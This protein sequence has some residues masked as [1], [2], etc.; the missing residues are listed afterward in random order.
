MKIATMRLFR[1]TITFALLLVVSLSTA[2][3]GHEADSR[4]RFRQI[5]SRSGIADNNIRNLQML[6]NGVMVLYT[7]TML[8]IYD[9]ISRSDLAFNSTFIPYK[10]YSTNVELVVTHDD[11][12]VILNGDR[13][14]YFDTRRLQ[15]EYHNDELF[16]TPLSSIC[17]IVMDGNNNYLIYTKDARLHSY[18]PSTATLTPIST[19][20]ALTGDIRMVRRGESIYILTRGGALFQYDTSLSTFTRATTSLIDSDT[21]DTSRFSL[22]VGSS[23]D[24]FA[25]YD[26]YLLRINA[27]T[28]ASTTLSHIPERVENIYTCIGIDSNERLWIG[29][30]KG[31]LSIIDLNTGTATTP[32]IEVMGNDQLSSKLEISNLYIDPKGG[33]WVATESEGVLY[34]HKD[35]FCLTTINDRI[36]NENIKCMTTTKQGDILLGTSHGLYAYNPARDEVSLPHDSLRDVS[37]ISLY[38]D[39]RDRIWLGAFREGIFCIDNGKIRN[40]SYPE[41]PTIEESY[42]ALIPNYNCVR[43]IF[44]DSEGNFWISVYGGLARFDP[45]SGEIDLVSKSHPEIAH[46]MFVR[47]IEQVGDTICVSSNDGYFGYN[48]K[49]DNLEQHSFNLG[50]YSKCNQSIT[51]HYGV[52]WVATSMG[53]WVIFNDDE[54]Q[55]ITTNDGLV[56]NNIIALAEDELSNIWAIS[57]SAASRISILN[58]ERSS[59]D[60]RTSITSFTASDGLNAGIL[61]ERSITRDGCGNLYVGGSHGFSIITPSKLYQ[62]REEIP[63]LLTGLSINNTPINVGEEYNGRVVL[64]QVIASTKEITLNHNESFI[65]FDITNR[66]YSN[67]YHTL[68]RY[69][70]ENFDHEWHQ[71][72]SKDGGRATYTLLKPGKYTFKVIAANNGTDWNKKGTSISIIVKPPFYATRLAYAI[73]FLLFLLLMIYILHLL[74][75]RNMERLLKR[76]QMEREKVNQMKFR[77][78]TNIS[79]ELRTPLSL[80]LLPLNNIIRKT[81]K[82][83]EVMPQLLTIERNATHLLSLVNHLLDF[84]KL[85]MG[86]EKLT[87]TKNNP[88]ELIETIISN[89]SASANLKQICLTMVDRLEY[90]SCYFD[91]SHIYKVINNL[92]S[93]AIK[94]TPQGG[95]VTITLRQNPDNHLIIEVSDTG[96]GISQDDQALIFDRFYQVKEQEAHLAGSGI[97][98][99]LVKQYIE[100]HKGTLSVESQLGVGSTFIID[101]PNEEPQE[102]EESENLCERLE[103]GQEGQEGQEDRLAESESYESSDKFK[104][105][106][107]EDN[108]DLREYLAMELS[109]LKYDIYTAVDGEDG[110]EKA[111][112]LHPSLIISD[113]MMPKSDGFTLCNTLKND[114]NTSH[115]PIILL[116][117]RTADDVR[118]EGYKAGA[119]AYIA[120]PFSF[121][122]LE[123]RIRKLIE[124]RQYRYEQIKSPQEIKTLQISMSSL[125][126]KLMA[127]IIEHIEKNMSNANYSVEQL[128]QDVAMHRMNLYR[129]I[130]SIAGMPPSEF[131]RMLRIKRAAQLFDQDSGL[132]ILA[133]SEMV[134]FNTPKYFTNYFKKTYGVTPSQY[135]LEVKSKKQAKNNANE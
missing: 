4:Y 90:R 67:P 2:Y 74:N 103:E 50:V 33:V 31:G 79:H 130:Q 13:T 84:R 118:Y 27:E 96:V 7:P 55:I 30:S 86:G 114:I 19:P 113:I 63:P 66:N 43:S 65:S 44:E 69:Q 48:P 109:S 57:P 88:A 128:S 39:S 120:K 35:I 20:Q 1:R 52:R 51:D 89:F 36:E 126:E 78:F 127:Q 34:H 9:G 122:V 87:L 68:Y 59:G 17:S 112:T 76:E 41:M 129:K 45:H 115:I 54:S 26:H 28:F 75:V 5:N 131:L 15:F 93:N 22:Q 60:F 53:L 8:S 132:S 123:I 119:D 56:S 32:K 124:E 85:E 91:S 62:Q 100:L 18:N 61:F 64:E 71:I 3:A 81:A 6:P 104:I 58:R 99:H 47:D 23:G 40:Y 116:T 94:F 134:G 101:L 16:S 117:A 83:S 72:N 92:I 46:I 133:I 107:V 77:F 49:S 121:D 73:Y 98:L 95:S 12:L 11:N 38:K 21:T 70:L 82:E 42:R 97:G 111:R 135:V 29:S 25:M 106:I 110:I 80:I 125:D 102:T 14:W 105:L 108:P 37:C 24:I 10:E